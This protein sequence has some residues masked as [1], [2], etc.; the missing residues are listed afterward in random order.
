MAVRWGCGQPYLRSARTFV[1]PGLLA[2]T[3]ASWPSIQVPVSEDLADQTR[4]L[5]DQTRNLV[6]KDMDRH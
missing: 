6:S 1:V 2:R 4:N 5:A 3:R